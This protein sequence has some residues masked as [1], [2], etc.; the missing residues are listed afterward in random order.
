MSPKI[1]KPKTLPQSQEP[2]QM[3]LYRECRLLTRVCV[4]KTKKSEKK[5]KTKTK[6]KPNKKQS[7]QK[8]QDTSSFHLKLHEPVPHLST[9]LQ[10]SH[11]F[12]FWDLRGPP[13]KEEV[14]RRCGAIPKDPVGSWFRFSGYFFVTRRLPFHSGKE[15]NQQKQSVQEENKGKAG[16]KGHFETLYRKRKRSSPPN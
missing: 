10:R 16:I 4:L 3:Q 7:K 13:E 14:K 5:N 2:A 8:K 6:Q 9:V 15:R 12:K 1:V 11:F